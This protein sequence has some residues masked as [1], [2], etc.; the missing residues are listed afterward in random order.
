M[1]S[2]CSERTIGEDGGLSS[3]AKTKTQQKVIGS[4]CAS[5]HA[6]SIPEAGGLGLA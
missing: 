2:N 1:A 4:V 3:R 6:T 5:A